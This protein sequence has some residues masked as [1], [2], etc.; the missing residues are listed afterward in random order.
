MLGR[1]SRFT[2][3]QADI[4]LETPAGQQIRQMT[5]YTALG[6]PDEVTDYLDGFAA[7]ADADEL[8]VAGQSPT[9]PQRLRSFE[10]LA[11]AAGL[12]ELST[13]PRR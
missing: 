11:G 7:H 10:L 4:L 2:D 1:G 12:G 5:T 13:G 3:E 6:T 8:I 9:A